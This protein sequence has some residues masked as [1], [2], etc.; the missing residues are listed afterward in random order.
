MTGTTIDPVCGMH[1]EPEQA[2]AESEYQG[3]IYYF[4]CADC[5]RLFDDDPTNYVNERTAEHATQD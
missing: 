1:V 4:C 2:A 5:K 3:Q